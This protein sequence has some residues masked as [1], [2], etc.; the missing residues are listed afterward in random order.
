MFKHSLQ[1]SL[2]LPAILNLTSHDMFSGYFDPMI[3]FSLD[4]NGLLYVLTKLIHLLKQKSMASCICRCVVMKEASLYASY[5]ENL[6]GN[7]IRRDRMHPVCHAL[8]VLHADK[9][10]GQFTCLSE[11]ENHRTH[12]HEC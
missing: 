11:P 7:D 4:E 10:A 8:Q 12:S 3:G 1:M 5:L 2:L 9:A 6:M